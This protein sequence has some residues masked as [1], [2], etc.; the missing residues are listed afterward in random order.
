MSSAGI[1]QSYGLFWRTEDVFWQ[2]FKKREL[3]G[4]PRGARTSQPTNFSE[5]VGIYVLYEGHRMIYVGHTRDVY[6]DRWDHFSWFGL[7]RPIRNGGLSSERMRAVSSI[8]KALDHMEA[9][10]IAAAEPSLNKQGGRF[11]RNVRRFIQVR[12]ERLGPTDSEMLR[13]LWDQSR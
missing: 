4:V 2:T 11:G 6:A 7:R 8:A 10:L 5:Q 1:I 12:D 9:V 13:D 3:L